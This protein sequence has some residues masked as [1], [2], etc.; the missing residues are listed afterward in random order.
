MIYINHKKEGVI[1]E[2]RETVKDL[3]LPILLMIL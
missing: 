3:S 2:G 1:M